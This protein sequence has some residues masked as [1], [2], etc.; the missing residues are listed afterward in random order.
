MITDTTVTPP[1]RVMVGLKK[2]FLSDLFDLYRQFIY[3][4]GTDTWAAAFEEPPKTTTHKIVFEDT[5]FEGKGERN[6]SVIAASVRRLGCSLRAYASA[7]SE[8]SRRELIEE[9]RYQ[10]RELE[11]LL[12]QMARL[13]NR[14][15]TIRWL[16][17]ALNGTVAAAVNNGR[18]GMWKLRYLYH[19]PLLIKW[20]FR[21]LG[22]D[23]MEAWRVL[24]LRLIEARENRGVS[25][26]PL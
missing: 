16:Y 2:A 11:A 8:V 23:C 15:E 7:E 4:Y 20:L 5:D 19:E 12:P 14:Y 10:N 1:A 25:K 22:Q 6:S 13:R 26:P 18:V 17:S 21:P 3:G 9:A 24:I